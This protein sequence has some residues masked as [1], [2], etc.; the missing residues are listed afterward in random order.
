MRRFQ[1]LTCLAL[2]LASLTSLST[3]A[4]AQSRPSQGSSSG[5][6]PSAGGGGSSR[7]SAPSPRPSAPSPSPRPSSQPSAP[8][9]S[10]PSPRPTTSAPSSRPA[11]S[12]S[13]D[14]P[15]PSSSTPSRPTSIP[16]PS[17]PAPSR[18][19]RPSSAPSRPS[20]GTANDSPASNGVRYLPR[21]EDRPAPA[22]ELT[23]Q[24]GAAVDSRPSW[25]RPSSATRTT[26]LSERDLLPTIEPAQPRRGF[27]RLLGS[28]SGEASGMGPSAARLTRPLSNADA[29]PTSR[30]REARPDA[31]SPASPSGIDPAK[32]SERYRRTAARLTN[33]KAEEPAGPA[34][35]R[36]DGDTAK[37]VAR[38]RAAH[39]LADAS[40]TA[41]KSPSERV[42][43]ARS[44]AA[45]AA[46]A[47]GSE[48]KPSTLRERAFAN[49]K[50]ARNAIRKNSPAAAASST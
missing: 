18:D 31:E 8:R 9:P 50:R 11:P 48:A 43:N 22:R 41:V 5:S 12:P 30:L 19:D 45:Q 28:T 36:L 4:V 46:A 24:S 21:V 33:E 7:P 35:E 37:R 38:A 29:G 6:R 27:P 47:A 10:A 13:Y 20:T 34:L 3:P 2:A 32:L 23:D 49:P 25:T 17:Y 39:E 42:A 15:R 14:A 44:K 40:P 26:P 16:P 1:L